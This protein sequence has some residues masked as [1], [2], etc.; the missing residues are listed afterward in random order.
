L[1]WPRRVQAR[2]GR[3]DDGSVRPVISSAELVRPVR[4]TGYP[5]SRP[6][7][8]GRPAGVQVVG[9]GDELQ[10]R[11]AA[12]KLPQHLAKVPIHDAGR[13]LLEQGPVVLATAVPQLV[14]RVGVASEQQGIVSDRT[15]S[16][17]WPV[18]VASVPYASP[19]AW[20]PRHVGTA[21]RMAPT[22]TRAGQPSCGA[23]GFPLTAPASRA[24]ITAPMTRTA[25]TSTAG[26]RD[27]AANQIAT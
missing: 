18:H 4:A 3:P 11:P 10:V 12:L 23:S 8:P 25:V 20:R 22:S 26:A 9:R 21:P 17:V 2:T 16:E 1:R 14:G 19:R 24:V 27:K 15:G 5:A 7:R 6:R 13:R